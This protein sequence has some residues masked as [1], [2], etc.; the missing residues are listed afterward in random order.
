MMALPTGTPGAYT[1]YL[2]GSAF[3]NAAGHGG[4]GYC[5][6]TSECLYST[7]TATASSIRGLFGAPCLSVAAGGHNVFFEDADGQ[8]WS[9]IWYGSSTGLPTA[10]RPLVD[11]PSVAKCAIDASSGRLACPTGILSSQPRVAS[12]ANDVAVEAQQ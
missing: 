1:Y 6:N 3:A 4:P 9:T 10:D 11:L 2:S 7:Y 12:K 8:L 5:D